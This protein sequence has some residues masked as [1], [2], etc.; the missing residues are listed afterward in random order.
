M[1]KYRDKLDIVVDV[2]K[3]AGESG[4]VKKTKIMYQ[5]NLSFR[6]LEKYLGLVLSNGFLQRDGS[7]YELTGTGIEFLDRCNR[8]FEKYSKAQKTLKDLDDERETL[9]GLC[10]NTQS[11]NCDLKSALNTKGE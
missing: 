3:T 7:K 10:D 5:A 6:L 8:L 4:G 9:Q 11:K 2:L 1:G